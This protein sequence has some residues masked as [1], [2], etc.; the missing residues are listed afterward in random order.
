M[1]QRCHLKAALGERIGLPDA[2]WE[3]VGALLP[4]ERGRGCRP[5]QANRRYWRWTTTGLSDAMLETLN[6]V[7]E[8]DASADMILDVQQRRA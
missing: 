1:I 3:I 4:A 7:V 2:E 5:A 8:R 6:E